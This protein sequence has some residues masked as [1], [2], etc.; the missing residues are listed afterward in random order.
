MNHKAKKQVSKKPSGFSRTLHFFVS[1]LPI[2]FKTES[3]LISERPCWCIIQ[4]G[5]L[6]TGETFWDVVGTAFY[7]WEDEKHLVG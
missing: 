4:M 2:P 6:Y 7:E 3:G 5:Y 1:R